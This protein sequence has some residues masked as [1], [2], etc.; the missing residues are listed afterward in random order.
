MGRV[1]EI[2]RRK[3]GDVLKIEASATVFEALKKVVAA[4]VGSILVTDDAG[5]VIG[6]MTERDYLRKIAVF[7]RTSH[8]TL[9]G[10]IM[11]SPI[12]YVTPETTVEESMAIMTDRR[13]RHLP[14]VENDEVVGIIS[15]GDVVKFQ[16][17]EQSF[18]IKYLTEYISGGR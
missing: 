4:N 17:R 15:I 7:G 13:I 1:S 18:Q 16:T 9:V 5:Q 6:I 11:T 10:E 14:V 3:S 12:M 2:L 8:D